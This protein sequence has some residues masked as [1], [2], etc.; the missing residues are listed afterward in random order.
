MIP[1]KINKGDIAES[2]CRY[3]ALTLGYAEQLLLLRARPTGIAMIPGSANCSRSGS[4]KFGPPAR[5]DDAIK[6]G[7]DTPAQGPIAELHADP[8]ASF[9]EKLR[10]AS[11]NSRTRSIVNTSSPISR[12]TAA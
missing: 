12:S 3:P 5:H 4:G 6:R 11:Y 7:L 8:R 1:N 10:A 2:P 9:R